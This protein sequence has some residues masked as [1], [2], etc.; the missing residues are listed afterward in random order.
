MGGGAVERALRIGANRLW[1]EPPDTIGFVLAGDL[2]EDE[3]RGILAFVRES[4]QGADDI[5]MLINMVGLGTVSQGGRRLSRETPTP[6]VLR[7]IAVIGASFHMRVLTT[8]TLKALAI[9]TRRPFE[10]AF[11]G[12]EPEARAWIADLRRRR[13]GGAQA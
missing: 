4:S 7:G 9:V 6:T 10:V 8:L 13:A 1:F 12:A 3:I 11:F 5:Y 2:S